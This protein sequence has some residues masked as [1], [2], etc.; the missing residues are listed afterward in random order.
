MSSS[1]MCRYESPES[2]GRRREH[3]NAL[4]PTGVCTSLYETCI[5]SETSKRTGAPHAQRMAMPLRQTAEGLEV[6]GAVRPSASRE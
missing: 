1:H 5:S 3:E 6:L 4:F 2:V